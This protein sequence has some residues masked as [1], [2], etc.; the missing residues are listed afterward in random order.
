[1]EYIDVYDEALNFIATMPSDEAHK[2]GAW[3]KVMHF[4]IVREE[5]KSQYLIFQKRSDS[6]VTFPGLFDITSAGHYQTGENTDN[7]REVQEELGLSVVYDK[8]I[9]LGLRIDIFKEEKTANRE[10]CETFLYHDNRSLNSYDIDCDEVVGLIQIEIN[11]GLNL[12]SNV[13]DNIIASGFEFD[14]T[15]REKVEKNYIIN[16]ESFVKRLDPY[17]GKMFMISKAYFDGNTQLFI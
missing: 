12:F 7:T 2:S 15:K 14:F 1:M 6:K 5:G 8:K 10:F 17:Y 4:W 9:H 11:D 13:V 16:R 3:H